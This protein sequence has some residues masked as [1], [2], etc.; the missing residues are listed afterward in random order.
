M[1][2]VTRRCDRSVRS[3]QGLLVERM[4]DDRPDELLEHAQCV[5]FDPLDLESGL[6]RI[7]NLETALGLSEDPDSL[8]GFTR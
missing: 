2:A 4:K 8:A 5:L 6:K 7:A 1:C 3:D